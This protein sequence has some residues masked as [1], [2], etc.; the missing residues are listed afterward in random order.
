MEKIGEQGSNYCT[1][2]GVT[3]SNTCGMVLMKGV[4]HL[5]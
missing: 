2:C 4:V 3:C 1:W 5:Y